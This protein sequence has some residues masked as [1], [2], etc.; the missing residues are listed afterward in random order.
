[1]K[2]GPSPFRRVTVLSAATVA[3]ARARRL[4]ELVEALVVEL[5]H[6]SRVHR[7]GQPHARLV[8]RGLLGHGAAEVA[9]RQGQGPRRR[10]AARHDDLDP[11]RELRPPVPHAGVQ[12]GRPVDADFKVDN[13]Q[14]SA[15]TMQTQADADITN[16]ASVLLIDA[17]D[18]GS[19]AAIEANAKSK[20]VAV[21]DYDRLTL[22]GP[23]AAPTSASTTSTSASSSAT[24][25]SRASRRGR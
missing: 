2:L 18:S 3:R 16:G 6:D 8:H 25:R 21:I 19:G 1:M 9:G 24:A 7:R 23:T 11:V 15:Q 22:G 5:H 12:G 10:A 17:I 20:G 13:A 4:R 14:G